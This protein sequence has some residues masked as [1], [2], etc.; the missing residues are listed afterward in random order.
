MSKHQSGKYGDGRWV[1]NRALA[2]Y[3]NVSE[4]TIW[5]WKRDPKLNVPPA[6]V[7]N[8]IDY[9]DIDAWDEWMRAQVVRRLEG[10]VP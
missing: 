1:R 6:S 5:R 7:I 3:F 9:N 10:A 8:D 4:M 2:R